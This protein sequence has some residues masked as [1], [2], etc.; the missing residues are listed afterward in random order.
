MYLEAARELGAAPRRAVVVEDALSGVEAG[1][2]GG[3]ALVLGVD[4]GAGVE[5]LRAHGADL[6]VDDLARTL[7]PDDPATDPDDPATRTDPSPSREPST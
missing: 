2:A 3:F 6:V 4:R 5:A 1:R 7:D